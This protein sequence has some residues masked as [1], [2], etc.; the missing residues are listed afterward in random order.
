MFRYYIQD[1]MY[2]DAIREWRDAVYPMY[3]IE[4]ISNI[5]ISTKDVDNPT[6]FKIDKDWHEAG[7]NG[8]VSNGRFNKGYLQLAEEVDWHRENNIFDKTK[9]HYE[10]GCSW[11]YLAV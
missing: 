1:A 2:M 8:F 3:M 5:V 9:E 10:N 6:L 4:D 7:R 11:S